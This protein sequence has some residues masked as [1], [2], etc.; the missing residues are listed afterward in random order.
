MFSHVTLSD[1]A[2]FPKSPRYRKAL[3]SRRSWHRRHALGRSGA[4]TRRSLLRSAHLGLQATHSMG[5]EYLYIFM[6]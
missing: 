6:H 2:S 5:L 1:L 3:L 4:G